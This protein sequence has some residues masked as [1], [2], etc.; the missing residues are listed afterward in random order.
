MHRPGFEVLDIIENKET[1]KYKLTEFKIT[2]SAYLCNILGFVRGTN[3]S[4]KLRFEESKQFVATYRPNIA[5][6]VPTNFIVLCDI[7]SES[8]FGAK[9]VNILKLLSTNFDPNKEIIDLSFYQDEFIDLNLKEFSSI[10]IQVVDTT[11]NL[12][13]SGK[14][15]PTRC[16]LQ[17]AKKV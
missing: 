15:Y 17:F 14:S 1:E 13:K 16:Q 7:V 8:I 12:I 5:L 10:R 3:K 9:S 6:L 11:G 4:H 2:M